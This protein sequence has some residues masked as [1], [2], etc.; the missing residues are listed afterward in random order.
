MRPPSPSYLQ[1]WPPVLGTLS[2]AP[3]VE[4][5]REKATISVH[6]TLALVCL[7]L[8][9]LCNECA[10]SIGACMRAKS[11]T[12]RSACSHKCDGGGCP[13]GRA[14]TKTDCH[15]G[16]KSHLFRG[17]KQIGKVS[18]QRGNR[19]LPGIIPDTGVVGDACASSFRGLVPRCEGH[20]AAAFRSQRRD[21]RA[22]H[23]K[24]TGGCSKLA[25]RD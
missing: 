11:F 1:G 17:A 5:S 19:E 20:F 14:A 13:H 3:G 24:R 22:R 23:G 6:E 2:S 7:A 18:A 16:T 4:F 25:Q 12:K 8:S 10:F 15:P 21:R 9:G